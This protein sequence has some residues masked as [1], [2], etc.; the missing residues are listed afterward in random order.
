MTD[1]DGAGSHT[2]HAT[3]TSTPS[4]CLPPC[5]LAWL[6]VPLLTHI[7]FLM[8]LNEGLSVS[9]EVTYKALFACYDNPVTLFNIFYFMLL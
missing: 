9:C 4:R 7:Q 1:V 3:H 5:F 8:L 6:S 2:L